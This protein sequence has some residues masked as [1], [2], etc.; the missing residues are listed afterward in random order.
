MGIAEKALEVVGTPKAYARSPNFLGYFRS[1]DRQPRT[2][3]AVALFLRSFDGRWLTGSLVLSVTESE[4][5]AP[6]QTDAVREALKRLWDAGWLRPLDA[7]LDTDFDV[8]PLSRAD[9]QLVGD[10]CTLMLDGFLIGHIFFY[11][12]DEQLVVYPHDDNGYG[13]FAPAGTKAAVGRGFLQSAKDAAFIVD[14]RR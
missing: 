5:R 13:V 14:V 2:G 12:G 7:P 1:P 3:E 6:A 8:I 10:L 9:R 11:W 4:I